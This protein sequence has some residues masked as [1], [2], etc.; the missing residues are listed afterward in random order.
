MIVLVW[1]CRIR[2]LSEPQS[3]KEKRSVVRRTL[4]R[5]RRDFSLSAAEVGDHEMLNVSRLGFCSVGTDSALLEGVVEKCRRRLE[6]FQPIEFVEEDVS[7]E[8]YG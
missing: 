1:S 4:E 7:L 8:H 6:S 2:I 3:L 5:A